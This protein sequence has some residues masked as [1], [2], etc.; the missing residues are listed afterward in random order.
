MTLT[1]LRTEVFRRLQEDQSA[2]V[3]WTVAEVSAALNEGYHEI[4]D[5]TEWYERWVTIDLLRERPYYDLR[6]LLPQPVLSVGS[7]LNEQTNRWLTPCSTRDLDSTYRKWEQTIGE[8]TH[9]LLR[10]L[11]WLRYWPY[12]GTEHGTVKQYY[13]S[14]PPALEAADDSPGIPEVLHYGLVEFALAD[15]WAQDA[16]PTLATTAWKTY[17]A[18]EQALLDF[19][20]GRAAVPMVHGMK[21]GGP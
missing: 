14:L 17:L 12:S 7:A 1:E 3:F 20:Q 16:E 6:Y 9:T 19:V 4:S 15:L 13:T 11:W 8:P 10:G 18:Y 5:A 2:P 21:A